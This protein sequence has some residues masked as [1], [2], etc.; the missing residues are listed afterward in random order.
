[1]KKTLIVLL[2]AMPFFL[3]GD[4]ALNARIESLGN[5]LVEMIWERAIY[6]G[7]AKSD[8]WSVDIKKL[9]V[10]CYSVHA[11]NIDGR[12]TDMKVGCK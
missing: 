10:N 9:S 6:A 11:V 5:R 1:M 7:I 2:L 4:A 3:H 12:D 8:G